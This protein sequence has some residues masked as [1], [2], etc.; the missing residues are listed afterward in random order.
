MIKQGDLVEVDLDRFHGHMKLHITSIIG[1]LRN[2]NSE[3]IVSDYSCNRML[4]EI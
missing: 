4:E 2:S 1:C 3:L